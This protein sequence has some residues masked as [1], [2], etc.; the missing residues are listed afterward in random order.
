MKFFLFAPG[1]PRCDNGCASLEN[2]T[3]NP[4]EADIFVLYAREGMRRWHDWPANRPGLTQA[5]FGPREV[6]FDIYPNWWGDDHIIAI[7]RHRAEISLNI[8]GVSQDEGTTT[9]TVVNQSAMQPI[10]S[11]P[12]QFQ[13]S[14]YRIPGGCRG[15]IHEFLSRKQTPN[16][17]QVRLS[18]DRRVEGGN[19]TARPP[20]IL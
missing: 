5:C 6:N 13:Q 17:S 14:P 1:D 19:L 9:A 8:A 12:L 3:A 10:T 7:S 18:E 2:I 11:A 4:A 15:Q 16:P 20:P